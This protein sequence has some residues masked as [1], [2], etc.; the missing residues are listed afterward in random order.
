MSI[1]ANE[2]LEMGLLNKSSIQDNNEQ[3]APNDENEN[4]E[5]FL[6][7]NFEK[8]RCKIRAKILLTIIFKT[9]ALTLLCY[10][11]L[12]FV[13]YFAGKKVITKDTVKKIIKPKVDTGSSS[14]STGISEAVTK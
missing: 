6:Y 7:Q 3:Q 9:L 12:V 8:K 1:N 11:Y 4:Q 13:R 5:E 14:K 2:E 10:E